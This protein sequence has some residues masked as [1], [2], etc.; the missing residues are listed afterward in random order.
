MSLSAAFENQPSQYTIVALL[1]AP[2][3]NSFGMVGIIAKQQGVQYYTVFGLVPQKRLSRSDI[4]E[5]YFNLLR[6]HGHITEVQAPLPGGLSNPVALWV[7]SKF[8]ARA[9]AVNAP[10][11]PEVTQ[12]GWLCVNTSDN[13]TGWYIIREPAEAY[14]VLD[15]WVSAAATEV[16]KRGRTELVDLMKWTLPCSAKTMA[17]EYYTRPTDE[18][19]AA[20]LRFHSQVSGAGQRRRSVEELLRQYEET[21]TLILK[22]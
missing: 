11:L 13:R 19:K 18:L 2:F 4:D 1:D 20:L 12:A 16:F 7:G 6:G 21:R 10:P 22:S 9:Q 8:Y 3:T 15:D 5:E 14:K 17:A